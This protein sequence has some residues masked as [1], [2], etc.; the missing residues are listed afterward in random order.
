MKNKIKLLIGTIITVITCS[1]FIITSHAQENTNNGYEILPN[2]IQSKNLFD[3]TNIYRYQTTGNIAQNYYSYTN[4]NTLISTHNSWVQNIGFKIYLTANTTYTISAY[5]NSTSGTAFIRMSST[6]ADA[7]DLGY[8]NFTTNNV[9]TYNY[10]TF[11]TTQESCV[12]SIGSASGSSSTSY[13]K[14]IMLNKGSTPLNYFP[15]ASYYGNNEYDWNETLINENEELKEQLNSIP[16]NYYTYIIGNNYFNNSSIVFIQTNNETWENNNYPSNITIASNPLQTPNTTINENILELSK[17]FNYTYN[18]GTTLNNN[19]QEVHIYDAQNYNTNNYTYISIYP[20]YNLPSNVTL[21]GAMP[22]K[23]FNITIDGNNYTG[24]I[25]IECTRQGQNIAEATYI[26]IERNVE[27]NYQI[28]YP[29][30]E[31]YLNEI[32]IQT[33]YTNG[34]YQVPTTII[35]NVEMIKSVNDYQIGYDTATSEYQNQIKQINEENINLENQYRVIRANYE[36][37]LNRYNNLGTNNNE[38]YGMVIGVA[39][40]PINVFK[41]IFNFDILGINI[42]EFIFGIASLLIIIWLIKKII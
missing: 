6:T 14:N 9:Y 33:P 20:H 32:Q 34:S 39:E 5:A 37:L 36:D 38:L 29:E 24:N 8:M 40:T 2:E 26:E 18:N 22:L 25:R 28:Y 30:S 41:Q 35:C 42:S 31:L 27:G 12:I 21:S 13:F 23:Y 7:T 15:Y 1:I 16:K 19:L 10:F 4:D 17:L 11:T 3:Y